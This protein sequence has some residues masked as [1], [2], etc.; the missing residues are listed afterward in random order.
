[1]GRAVRTP[2]QA[3]EGARLLRRG[4]AVWLQLGGDAGVQASH[5]GGS[6]L[7]ARRAREVARF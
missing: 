3:L 7:A 4:W 1:M 6:G 2:G 5:A